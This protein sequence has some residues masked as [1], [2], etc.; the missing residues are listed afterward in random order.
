MRAWIAMC[1]NHLG[2]LLQGLWQSYHS[3][4]RQAQP[5]S[6][7]RMRLNS[8]DSVELCY[9]KMALKPSSILFE[10]LINSTRHNFD[11]VMFWRKLAY[12][13]SKSVKLVSSVITCQK[14]T[15]IPVVR[16]LSCHSRP[17]KAA[18][19]LSFWYLHWKDQNVCANLVKSEQAKSSI[20]ISCSTYFGRS[21]N[22]CVEVHRIS[23]RHLRLAS[24]LGPVTVLL[25]RLYHCGYF[26]NGN[27]SLR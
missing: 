22:A 1:C 5:W 27:W 7:R 18:H 10:V 9:W 16:L 15:M 17:K 6:R 26:R 25:I 21:S 14:M 20:D 2:M 3:V 11:I 12:A 8:L 19:N 4:P 24:T 23:Y 13:S